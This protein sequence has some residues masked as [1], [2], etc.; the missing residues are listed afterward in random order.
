MYA[1]RSY[2]AIYVED[3]PRFLEGVVRQPGISSVYSQETAREID[4]AVRQLLDRAF[5]R[6]SAILTRHR[7]AL[8][9]T[10]A[11]LL[12]KETLEADELPKLPPEPRSRAAE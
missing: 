6:A 2:Y 9:E 8:D 11:K 3:Q 10:A 5:E 4:C 1:I 12:E 7:A